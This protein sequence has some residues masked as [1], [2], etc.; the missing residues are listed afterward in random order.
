MSTE[1]TPATD[2]HDDHG[3]GAPDAPAA[4]HGHAHPKWLAHHFDTPAQ[5]FDTAK[6]GM[7]A[8]LIQE[9]LFFSGLFVCYGIYRSWYPHMFVESSHQLNKLMGGANTIV[10]LFS[11]LTAA[12]AVRS[13]QTGNKQ[14]TSR[15]LIITMLC[16]C[17]FLVIK[18]FEYR[19]KFETGC[20]PGPYFHPHEL[21]HGATLPGNAHIFYSIYFM[22]TG[23]HGVHVLIGIGVI[24]WVWR[25]N[26]RGDFSKEYFTP[27]DLVAL[28]WHLVDLVW[29][30]LFPLLYLI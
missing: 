30:Y 22:M 10:L 13:S 29:I 4:G 8:F 17:A 26:E 15:F 27:V 1:A 3:H 14:A 9:L 18:F 21:S 24:F 19:H 20:L 6:L 16:A 12:L 23:V 25:R 5:Q 2:A 28:Y 7:W 11:S